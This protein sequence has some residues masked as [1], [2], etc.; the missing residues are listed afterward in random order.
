[1]NA[2]AFIKEVKSG[3]I[4]I[5]EHTH[6]V[7]EE[8]KKINSKYNYLNT[9]S[10]DLALSSAKSLKKNPK[11]RLAGLPITVK[12]CICVKGVETT[13]GSAI[14]RGYKPL[15]NATVIDKAIKKAQ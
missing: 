7:L 8:V 2:A 13:A 5:V 12:D 9:I 14:L 11:G 6:N 10:E 3:K 1:M 15:F 4:D